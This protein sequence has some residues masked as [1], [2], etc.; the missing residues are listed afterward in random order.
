MLKLIMT[1]GLPGCGKST[2]AN[3]YVKSNENVVIVEKDLFRDKI[4]KDN[5]VS[6]SREN[7]SLFIIPYWINLIEGY[8]KKGISV[9]SSD[10]NLAKRNRNIL[11]QIAKNFNAEL[12]VKDFSDVDLELCIER[13]SFREG[14][15][16]VGESRIRKIY[17]ESLLPFLKEKANIKL[18]KINEEYQNNVLKDDKTIICD[19]DGTVALMLDRTPFNW[20]KVYSDLPIKP[21]I[22]LLKMYSLNGYKIIFVSG[23]DAICREDTEKWLNDIANIKYEKLFMR[24]EGDIRSD[25]FVKK[26]IYENEI[27]DQY[28]VL[29]VF[30]DRPQV[31]K[32]WR[33]LNL[34]VFDVN[35]SGLVF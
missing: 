25:Y 11:A 26:E 21:V 34:F 8:L 15:K 29:M 3:E 4:L 31:V 13:D 20:S 32:L 35:Q 2:W 1:I 17:K 30:D 28:N 14:D 7:E 16:K 33:E 19:I 5:K 12:I 18:S 27:K 24:K 9:I 23:R 10:T 22:D 6:F